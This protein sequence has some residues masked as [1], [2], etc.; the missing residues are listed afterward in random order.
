MSLCQRCGAEVP[1]GSSFCPQCGSIFPTQPAQA[2]PQHSGIPDKITTMSDY[3]AKISITYAES[4]SRLEL[5]VRIVLHFVYGLIAGIWGFLA[6]IAALVQ[7]F[8]ILILGKRAVS[9]WSFTAGYYRFICRAESYLLLLTD[10]RPP[11]S[12]KP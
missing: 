8:H 6:A 10:H 1:D 4:A 3:P 7:W 2:Q 5:L 9:L 12:G 11:I